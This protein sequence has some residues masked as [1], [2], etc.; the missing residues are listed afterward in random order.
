M[1]LEDVQHVVQFI[2]HHAKV[3]A[4]LLPGHIP[5]YKRDDVQLLYTLQHNQAKCMTGGN[6]RGSLLHISESVATTPPTDHS[7]LPKSS[8]LL[9]LFEKLDCD[10]LPQGRNLSGLNV[11]R[12]HDN[13]LKGASLAQLLP[14]HSPCF[15]DCV[16]FRCCS[17]IAS[18]SAAAPRLRPL[19]LLL[20]DWVCCSPI[21]SA[22]Q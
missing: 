10:C 3:N 17:P 12:V 9:F 16:R 8:Q 21:G 15:P 14:P 19:Q 4:I 11:M 5:G 7:C 18:V 22:A 2:L 13:Y 1:S 20:P 6:K